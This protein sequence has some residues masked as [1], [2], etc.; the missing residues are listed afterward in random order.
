VEL[1]PEVSVLALAR[2]LH[3]QLALTY[4]PAVVMPREVSF[5][6]FLG[7]AALLEVLDF[8]DLGA[9]VALAQLSLLSDAALA[10]RQP[11]AFT[12][13][14]VSFELLAASPS[15]IGL[16]ALPGGVIGAEGRLLEPSLGGASV[17]PVPEPAAAL[18][19]TAGVLLVA[20]R[21]R[22]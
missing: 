15:S 22:R 8:V 6:S 11:S 2:L 4:D 16:E 5:G 19:F 20:W 1:H 7:D 13:A 9:P 17:R 12:L 21:A 18:V 10:A 3:L 14:N